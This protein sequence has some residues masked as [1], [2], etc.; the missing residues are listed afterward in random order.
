M[1]LLDSES[2]GWTTTG[3]DV[4][5]YSAFGGTTNSA[6]GA[7]THD[8]SGPFGDNY[9][10]LAAGFGIKNVPAAMTHIFCGFR[11]NLFNNGSL[12]GPL[13]LDALGT[14]Q[15]GVQLNSSTGSIQVFRGNFIGGVSLGATGGG[16]VP[17]SGWFYLEVELVISATVGVVNVRVNGVVVL[18]L[19]GQNTIASGGLS[20]ISSWGMGTNNHVI[21]TTHWY[22]C[23]NTGSA[24]WNTFLGD[25]RVQALFPVS[26]DVVQFTPHGLA[27]NWQNAAANPPV[28]G[29]DFNSSTTAGNQDTFNIQ[30][31]SGTTG[32]VFGVH[33][34]LISQKSDAGSRQF[35][36]VLKSGAS[37]TL[38]S[39]IAV[40]ISPDQ[41]RTIY[42]TDP[43]TSAQFT[44]AAVN[45]LKIGYNLA[46]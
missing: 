33:V 26:N 35:K 42:Q 23:D 9:Y 44:A 2:F 29:T 10:N 6:P 16:V 28:P 5:T 37:T 14:N 20:N 4:S 22:L 30:S 12:G 31:L 32:V 45:A 11:C 21:G 17:T 36:T 39:T 8:G 41:Y 38:G 13:F 19:S 24:P 15:I 43:A 40:G 7:I 34:K 27:A 1:T 18:S 3:T 46:A 25:T